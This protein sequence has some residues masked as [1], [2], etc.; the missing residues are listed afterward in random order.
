MHFRMR[1]PWLVTVVGAAAVLLSFS[2]SGEATAADRHVTIQDNKAPSPRDGFDPAQGRWQFNPNNVEV[3]RGE[4]VVFNNP[5]GRHHEH[6]VTSIRRTSMGPVLPG[7]F[8]AGDRFESLNI[9]PGTSFILETGALPQGHYA[10]VCRLHPWM[11]GG[12]T[13]VE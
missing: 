9:E 1:W 6:T 8:V 10:Y 11:N 2:I 3:K 13:V 12:I 5:P 4:R 7:T